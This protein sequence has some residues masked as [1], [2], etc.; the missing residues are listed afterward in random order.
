MGVENVH[1]HSSHTLR[2]E[3]RVIEFGVLGVSNNEIEI[4][5]Y[6]FEAEKT[7]KAIKSII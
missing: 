6:Q 7:H 2:P 1:S 3:L 4:L 5:L